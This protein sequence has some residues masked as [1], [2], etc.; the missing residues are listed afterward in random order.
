MNNRL[1]GGNVRIQELSRLVCD[2]PRRRCLCLTDRLYSVLVVV[3]LKFVGTSAA[4]LGVDKSL[5]LEGGINSDG[6]IH[7][8]GGNGL[9][10]DYCLVVLGLGDNR[11][12]RIRVDAEIWVDTHAIVH[13]STSI[14]VDILDL[15]LWSK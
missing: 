6:W 9:V 13:N 5:V 1:S 12:V 3:E 15:H 2:C 10:G 4:V 8:L 14:V 11:G 7:R